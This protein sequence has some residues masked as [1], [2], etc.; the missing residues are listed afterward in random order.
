M[1]SKGAVNIS[2]LF[3]STTYS[4]VGG[5]F[6]YVGEGASVMIDEVNANSSAKEGGGFAFVAPTGQLS[7][8]NGV[9]EC[10]SSQGGCLQAEEEA[11]VV[12]QNVT[13]RASYALIDGGFLFLN[14]ASSAS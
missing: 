10:S 4:E 6:I 11:N 14:A 8:H 12:L 3:T 2:A 5:G 9:L 7:I 13:A 1:D